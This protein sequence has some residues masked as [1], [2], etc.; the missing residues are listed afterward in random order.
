M[1]NYTLMDSA[2]PASIVTNYSGQDK[3]LIDVDNILLIFKSYNI[4]GQEIILDFMFS[5]GV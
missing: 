1:L 4:L 2:S 5:R 3:T